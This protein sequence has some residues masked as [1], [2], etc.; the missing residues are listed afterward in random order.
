MRMDASIVPDGATCDLATPGAADRAR[1]VLVGHGFS[2][3]PG[4]VGRAVRTLSLSPAGELS[5][6][7]TRIDVGTRPARIAFVP[8]GTI[9]LVLGADGTL[10]SLRVRDVRTLE[11]AGRVTLPPA[12]YGD[13]AIAPDGRSVVVPGSNVT[14]AAG[15]SVV[16]IGCDGSLALEAGAFYG[17]RLAESVAL[18]PG[19]R[20][21]V[22]GGQATFAPVDTRDLRILAIGAGAITELAAFDVFHDVIDT[23]RIAASPDGTTA[24]VPNASPF[25]TE[26]G[27]VAVLAL[28][29]AASPPTLRERVR[30]RDLADAHE[31][32]F[33]TDGHTALVARAEP[34][35]I[36]VLAD[37]TGGWALSGEVAGVGLADAIAIVRRG[38]Q[39]DLA[40]VA[41]VDAA[42]GSNVARLRITG[43]GVVADLGQLTLG[44]GP[45]NIPGA[46]DVQP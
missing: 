8:S 2:A 19:G 43:P 5:D 12:D 11:P 29:L 39:K 41:S 22:L 46:L 3:T 27:Q 28:D 37:V 18:L 17:L 16:R 45:E 31:A 24:I 9:A 26:G 7:G 36:A 25:S 34:G 42:A 21:L 23:T 30:L 40:L 10:V 6:D 44:A 1:V 38:S 35:R 33:A 20:A 4:V 13:L 14:T 32:A 15:V